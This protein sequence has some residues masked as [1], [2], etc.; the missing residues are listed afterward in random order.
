MCVGV[1]PDCWHTANSL[2]STQ[3]RVVALAQ[4]GH[5]ICLAL[6]GADGILG[7]SH[8]PPVWD[9]HRFGEHVYTCC[10]TLGACWAPSLAVNHKAERLDKCYSSSTR[11][12]KEGQMH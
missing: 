10:V 7:G 4:Q 8:S 2:P 3:T 9:R 6:I 12:V 1:L 11:R 5:V